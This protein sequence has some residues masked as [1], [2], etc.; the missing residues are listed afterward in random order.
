MP[1]M[2]KMVAAFGAVA[3]S[4]G[5]FTGCGSASGGG[6]DEGVG[7]ADKPV[8]LT[9]WTWQPTDA[10]WKS[11]Y[12]S[13]QKKY[14]NIKI[15]WWRTSEMSDYQK[16]LQTA[17]AGG[18]GPDVFGVQA[19]S[20]VEQYGR[21]ADDMKKLANQYMPGWDS[22]VA[23]GAVEQTTNADG[24]MVAMPT[25]TSGSE[26]ILYNK[27]LL[28]ENGV[29]VPSTYDELLEA[30]K[31]LTSKGLMPLALG[32]KDGWHLD[33]IFVWLSNQYG[34]GD[35]YD[36]AAGKKSF[37]DKIFVKTMKAWKQMIDDGLFQDGAVGTSTY[38][39]ARDNY[40]YARKTAFFPT[41]SWHV[42]AV[43]PNDETK[44]TAIEKDELGMMEF[45]TVGDKDTGPTTGV[46][47]GLCVNKDSKKKE[48]AMKFI[49]FMTT[50]NGQQE[51]INTLQG[52]PVD[53]DMKVGVPD[54]ATESAEASIDL[55]TK[56]QAESKLAR[57]LTSQELNDEI[58]VQMQNIYTGDATVDSALK[59]IQTVNES[60]DR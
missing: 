54:D 26:Y 34:E 52:A 47:F 16:K 10:Q 21:F 53:K 24:K 18:D 31:T 56:G 49:E 4:V 37:T 3:M 44:G 9:F 48:T 42:S 23:E 17:M 45:P 14:P 25:I 60:I 33:D 40:F 32:A 6:A 39:D 46:D 11:I 20:T 5:L 43:L 13:F 2:K 41:G 35:V 55:V 27:T 7:T 8:T 1:K 29:K 30:N 36:A 15:K 19:G 58:A 12:A 51:W 22:K 50:G 38:P 28:D 59:S 57:K